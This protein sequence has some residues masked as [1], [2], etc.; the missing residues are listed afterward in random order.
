M[1]MYLY[2]GELQDVSDYKQHKQEEVCILCVC[3]YVSMER[4]SG[5]LA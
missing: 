3:M 2:L 4:E 5:S 1:S